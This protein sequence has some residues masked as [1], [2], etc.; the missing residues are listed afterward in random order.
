MLH[1][2]KGRWQSFGYALKGVWGILSSGTNMLIMLLAV[3]VVIAAG[4]YFNIDKHDWALVSIAFTM[5]IVAEGF[6]TAIERLTDLVHP[7]HDP[8]AGQVKDIASGAV[9]IAVLGSLVI[10][11]VVFGKYLG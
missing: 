6:N 4:I 2:I 5:V 8:K 10:A 1:W 9:L 7:H 11:W 3:V